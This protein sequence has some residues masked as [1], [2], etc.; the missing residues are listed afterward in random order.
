MI[1]KYQPEDIVAGALS[2]QAADK[3][4]RQDLAYHLVECVLG[5][6]RGIGLYA[7]HLFRQ[8]EQLGGETAPMLLF[9]MTGILLPGQPIF[10][11]AELAYGILRVCQETQW[12]LEQTMLKEILFQSGYEMI[13]S[14]SEMA[15]LNRRKGFA[16]D[17]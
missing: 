13:V 10:H 12:P 8:K 17:E 15:F 16:L 6:T 9:T 7:R 14:P 3:L 2:P 1:S 11:D 4:G 5:K